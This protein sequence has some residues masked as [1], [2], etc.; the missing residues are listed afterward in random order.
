MRSLKGLFVVLEGPDKSGKS[1]QARL[2]ADVKRLA[3]DQQS[4]NP[5]IQSMH[6]ECTTPPILM[7]HVLVHTVDQGIGFFILSR[8]GQQFGRLVDD[9][10]FPILVDN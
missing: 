6:D 2:L 1:T 4:G 8:Y 7:P 10:Q 5:Q 9:N 3:E